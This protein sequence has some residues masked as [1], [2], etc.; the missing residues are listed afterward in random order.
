MK[1]KAKYSA[2]SEVPVDVKAFY[3]LQDGEWVFN[4]ADF[5][6]LD[7]LLNPGLAANRDTIKSEKLTAV[8]ERDVAVKERDAAQAELSKASKPGT[9]FMSAEDKKALDDYK[10]L[11]TLKDVTDKLANEQ[12]VSEKLNLFSTEK[13]VRQLAKD[14]GLNEDA[15]VDFK[16]NSERGKNVVIV[17][18]TIKVK[19]EKGKEVE[20]RIPVVQ[21]T[22]NVNGKD[23]VTT[24]SFADFAKE[25]HF[26]EYLVTAIFNAPAVVEE[27]SKTKTFVAPPSLVQKS[28]G[29]GDDTGKTDVKKTVARFNEERSTRQMPWSTPKKEETT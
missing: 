7:A 20:R 24:K 5:E 1:Y 4:G 12:V 26:P 10:A 19:D 27:K 18:E 14:L 2:E 25:N 29:N 11:G 3:V 6:G 21:I 28:S 13:E 23:K 8:A 17:A 22:D 15:L 9:I 16:L